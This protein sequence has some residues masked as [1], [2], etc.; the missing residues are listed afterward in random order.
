MEKWS[1]TPASGRLLRLPWEGIQ[2][3]IWVD[4]VCGRIGIVLP[5]GLGCFF[6]PGLD[7]VARDHKLKVER[8]HLVIEV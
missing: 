3:K 1:P 7:P 8:C 6:G 4:Y 2:V 5:C